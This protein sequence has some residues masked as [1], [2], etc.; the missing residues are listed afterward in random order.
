MKD[1]IKNWYVRE[2]ATDELGQELNSLA[3]FRDL[4]EALDNYKDVY[5]V[6][7]VYDSIVRERVFKRLADIIGCDYSYIY[8]QWLKAV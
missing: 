5:N 1:N 4:F 8:E 7:G 6:L 3:T 2:Y